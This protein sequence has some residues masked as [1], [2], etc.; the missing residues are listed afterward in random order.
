MRSL[1]RL[2]VLAL[3]LG[4]SSWLWLRQPGVEA[5]PASLAR[6]GAPTP[7]EDAA[8]TA[9]RDRAD[10]RVIQVQGEITRTL[11]DDRDGSRHQ[12]FIMRTVSG[13]SLLVAHNI[14]I[15]PRLDG[16]ARGDAL[17]LQGEYVWNDQGGLMHWTHHDP[18]GNHRGGYIEWRGRRYQ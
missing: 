6:E 5:P 1:R 10:G 16:L 17:N 3:V 18:G 2:A 15:A 13:I 14:D 12:R 9:F 4:G 7:G 11:A 8:E